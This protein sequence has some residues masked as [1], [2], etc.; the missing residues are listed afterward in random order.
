[1]SDSTKF[2]L[3]AIDLHILAALQDDARTPNI[4][5]AE[6]IGLSPSPCSRRVKLLEEHEVIEGYRAQISR[7]AVGLSLTIFAG[8]NVERHS[9]DMADAFVAAVLDISGVIACHM[10][11][12][13]ID[14]LLEIVAVDMASYEKETLRALLALPVVRSV[15]SNFAMRT[16]RAAGPLPLTHR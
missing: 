12:G 11:S 5:L 2:A 4:T 14:F 9:Q 7:P 13:G 3:D 8:V 10:V 1:M 15:H 6:R 16:F